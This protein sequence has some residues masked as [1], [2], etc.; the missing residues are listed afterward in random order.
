MM[1]LKL[2][3]KAEEYLDVLCRQMSDRSVGS[4]GNRKATHFF[5]KTVHSFGWEMESSELDVIDWNPGTA[6]LSIGEKKI[7]LL[8]SPYSKGCEVTGELTILENVNDLEQG[9]NKDK[10]LLIQ[11]EL[12][13]EQLMPKNFVFYN[14]DHHKR[15]IDL[16][17][18]SGAKAIICA[19]TMN[20]SLAGGV[21]PFPLIEDGDFDIP[22]VY[23]TELIGKEICKYNGKNIFLKSTSEIKPAKA[24]NTLAKKCKKN[25]ES[26]V[27]S[28]H[29]DAKKG[30]PGA[31]DNATGV[32]VLMLLAELLKDYN[33]SKTIELVAFNGEDYFSAPGQMD[34]IRLYQENFKNIMFNINIDGAGYMEGPTAFSYYNIPDEITLIIKNIIQKEKSIVEGS[35]WHQGDHGIFIQNGCPA[36]AVSSDWFIKNFDTQRI[37][38]TIRDNHQIVN[39]KLLVSIAKTLNEVIRAV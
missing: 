35:Q 34:Y 23:T 39:C 12:A 4:E 11:G 3:R 20:P 15:I 28:A 5:L 17:E 31:I 21:Y 22:S 8:P 25:S 1:D 33:G 19:T 6:Y 10:I 24:F 27:N 37:T 32:I 26:I 14:P 7:D 2:L 16:L 36:L 30:T 29:I 18:R 38:H 9:N 13:S